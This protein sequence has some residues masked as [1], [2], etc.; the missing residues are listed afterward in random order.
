ME[1]IHEIKNIDNSLEK[2]FSE[3]EQKYE[4][5]LGNVLKLR[6]FF[7]KMA[8]IVAGLYVGGNDPVKT[9]NNE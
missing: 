4:E 8:K 9:E 3:E 7:N 5:I 6:E 2:F 1:Q